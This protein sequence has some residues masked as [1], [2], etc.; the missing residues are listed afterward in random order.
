MKYLLEDPE[1]PTSHKSKNHKDFLPIGL[2]KMAALLEIKG[3]EVE[4]VKGK[5]REN[6][7]LFKEEDS[8]VPDEIGIMSLFTYWIEY[9]RNSVK[10]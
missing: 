7:I 5:L 3:H 9:V 1:F 2:L 6:H 8:F 10:H 4:I